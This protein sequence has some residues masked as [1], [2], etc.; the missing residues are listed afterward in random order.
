MKK[1]IFILGLLCCQVGLADEVCK[2]DKTYCQILKVKP[3]IDR[4]WAR[5]L[6]TLLNKKA[7]E[8]NMN[9]MVSVAILMQESSLENIHT[10]KKY[11]TF[12]KKCDNYSC[13][14]VTSQVEE[15][16]DMTIAQIN[17]DTARR[18]GF[19]LNRLFHK[20]LEYAIDCHFKILKDKIA[21]CSSIAKSWSCYHSTTEGNRLY[22]IGLV[23]RYLK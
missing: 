16:F 4:D 7:K 9:P 8:Y 19:D 1:I 12:E 23:E 13:K 2:G 22:Y 15:A 17:I 20:D 10:Y 3:K 5:K 14:K 11:S 6:S 21:M 18:Y